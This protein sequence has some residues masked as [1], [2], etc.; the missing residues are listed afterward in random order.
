[1]NSTIVIAANELQKNFRQHE[2]LSNFNLNIPKGNIYGLLGQNGAGKTT[3][4][5][6]LLGLLKPSGGEAYVCDNIVTEHDK[7]YLS[8]VGSLIEIPAFYDWLTV[9]ENLSLHCDYLKKNYDKIPE[10][11]NIVGIPGTENNKISELS[12]GMKQRLAIGRALLG[13]PEILILDEPING[14]DPKGIIEIRNLLL[15][16]KQEQKLTILLS[17]H[18][19]SEL[20]KIADIIG[21]MHKGKIVS[22][23]PKA[24]FAKVDFDFEKQ[25][26]IL[27]Q[28]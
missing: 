15:Q 26:L 7:S 6:I 24:T 12:L 23:I 2:V 9:G 10:I 21:V 17:S 16:L 11:L 3:F 22:E 14:V 5:K 4:M 28:D 13:K 18:I 19:I 20:E 27:T 8:K 25:F 1:M